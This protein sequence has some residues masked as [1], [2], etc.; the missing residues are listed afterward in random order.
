MGPGIQGE[1]LDRYA[2]GEFG[3]LRLKKQGRCCMHDW[4]GGKRFACGNWAEI[5]REKCASVGFWPIRV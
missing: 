2:L 4:L 5:V 3:D 1:P